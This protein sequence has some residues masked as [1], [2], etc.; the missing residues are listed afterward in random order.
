M[1][2]MKFFTV[3]ICAVV[4][5]PFV[6]ANPIR[7]DIKVGDFHYN[8]THEKE[9]WLAGAEGHNYLHKDTIC[10]P[11]IISFK[12]HTYK[13]TG[14]MP[15]AINGIQELTVLYLPKSIIYIAEYAI[16]CCDNLREIHIHKNTRYISNFAVWG[17]PNLGR[18]IVNKKNKWYS[19]HNGFLLNKS[20]TTFIRCPEAIQGKISIDGKIRNV[21]ANAFNGSQAS[22][23]EFNS[24]IDFVGSSAFIWMLK[25]K[26]IIF[27]QSTPPY[28]APTIKQEKKHLRPYELR[29]PRE[30]VEKYRNVEFLDSVVIVK[31]I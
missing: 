15:Y 21:A 8:I 6:W 27:H 14:I 5:A 23:I 31:P 1:K 29:V 18:Y 9:V 3:L 26:Y 10:I 12:G 4:Y 22:S 25:L 17:C 24:E 28:L 30:S 16:G 19:S 2:R 11:E 7:F 13:V 20:E